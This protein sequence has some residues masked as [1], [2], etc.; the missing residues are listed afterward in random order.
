MTPTSTPTICEG[1][2]LAFVH[3]AGADVSLTQRAMK[4]R[5]DLMI[6]VL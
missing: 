2:C 3:G 4:E 5:C 6:G 1:E